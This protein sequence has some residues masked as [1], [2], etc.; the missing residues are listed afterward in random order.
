MEPA[1]GRAFDFFGDGGGEGDDVV[2]EDFLQFLL[3]RDEAGQVGKPFVA[4]GLDFDEVGCGHDA[5]LNER[6]A[7][8]EFDLEPDAELVFIRPDGPHFRA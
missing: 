2:V 1:A 6:L 8:K 5:L 7:G 3:A 4:A